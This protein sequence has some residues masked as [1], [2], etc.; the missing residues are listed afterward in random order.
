MSEEQL[1]T[2]AVDDNAAAPDEDLSP[3]LDTDTHG[4][5]GGSDDQGG[6]TDDRL[7]QMMEE[8]ETL[9]KRVANQ[10]RSWQQERQKAAQLEA[11]LQRIRQ[12]DQA[13]LASGINPDDLVGII[14]GDQQVAQ[15]AAAVPQQQYQQ[16]SAVPQTPDAAIQSMSQQPGYLTEEQ[17]EA[18]L[19]MREWEDKKREF[20]RNNS[21]LDTPELRRFFDAAAATKV[22]EEIQ[23]YGRIQSSV[24]DYR[25]HAE[26]ELR[27]MLT[28]L[29][30]KVQKAATETREKLNAQQPV[31]TKHKKEPPS[32]GDDENVDLTPDQYV[33]MFNAHLDKIRRRG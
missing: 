22:Q 5:D 15:N 26:K 1:G 10:T 20:F 32:G 29:E 17:L 6:G 31:D 30:K 2:P 3:S 24:Y 21:D 14:S 7:S 16:Q 25:D 27:K 13:L 4:Y 18:R 19:I 8:L 23:E 28:A 11:E 9:K 33:E 12:R